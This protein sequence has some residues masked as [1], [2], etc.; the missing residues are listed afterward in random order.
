MIT[1]EQHDKR[2]GAIKFTVYAKA[3]PQGDIYASS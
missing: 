3:E 1:A 2:A